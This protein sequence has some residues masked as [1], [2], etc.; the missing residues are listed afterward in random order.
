[1][2]DLVKRLRESLTWWGATTLTKEAAD[3]IVRLRAEIADGDYW[4]VR[5]TQAIEVG[6]CPICFETDEAGHKPGCPWGEDEARAE[7]AEAEIERLR[8]NPGD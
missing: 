2:D 6:M 8:A 5:A 1:M 7:R 4:Q 3:E